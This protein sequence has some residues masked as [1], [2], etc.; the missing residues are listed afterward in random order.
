VVSADTTIFDL[1]AFR[2]ELVDE[3]AGTKGTI[4]C[5]VFTNY[6]ALVVGPI[7]EVHFSL[8]GFVS[9]KPDLM[10]NVE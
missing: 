2:G 5:G 8:D 3:L 9:C 1:L 4:I 10:T 6:Y 7:F